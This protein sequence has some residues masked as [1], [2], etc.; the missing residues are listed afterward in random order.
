MDETTARIFKE[1]FHVEPATIADTTQISL[2]PSWDSM[3]YMFFIAQLEG[4]HAIE[5]TGDEIAGLRTM[6]DLKKTMASKVVAK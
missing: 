1:A 3:A 6:G 5:F 4:A 2:L